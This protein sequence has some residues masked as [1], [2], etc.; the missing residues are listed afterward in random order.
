MPSGTV[1][2]KDL[3]STR[4]VVYYINVYQTDER[5]ICVQGMQENIYSVILMTFIKRSALIL[6][7]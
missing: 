6:D 1:L 4:Y 3:S 2:L 5:F 7:I